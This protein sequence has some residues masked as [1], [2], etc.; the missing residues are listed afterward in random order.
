MNMKNRLHKSN[1]YT[2][3]LETAK[4]I[5]QCV[6][7]DLRISSQETHRLQNN[8]NQEFFEKTTYFQGAYKIP[9]NCRCKLLYA[10]ELAR[11]NAMQT[12]NLYQFRQSSKLQ[13]LCIDMLVKA[14]NVQKGEKTFPMQ[15][16]LP[17]I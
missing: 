6:L 12:G 13:N 17:Q 5:K 7:F 2:S 11:L 9:Q 15:K 8:C 1:F 10:A 4:P 14:L 16:Y 3:P